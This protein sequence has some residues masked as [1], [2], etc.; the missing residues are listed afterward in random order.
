MPPRAMAVS[1]RVTAWSS[2]AP[3]RLV[4]AQQ[5]REHRHVGELRRVADAALVG[6]TVL[7]QAFGAARAVSGWSAS[8]FA[9]KIAGLAESGHELLRVE[10]VT[11]S[12]LS[13]QAR[14]LRLEDAREARPP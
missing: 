14:G 1:V 2:R 8:G 11:S 3:R 12:R 10:R 7:K 6:I 5:Q 13:R 9:S 4:V